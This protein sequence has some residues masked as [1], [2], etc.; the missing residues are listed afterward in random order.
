MLAESPT[1]TINNGANII[2]YN[3]SAV[4]IPANQGARDIES[5]QL[6]HKQQ[7]QPLHKWD[8]RNAIKKLKSQDPYASQNCIL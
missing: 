5:Q 3:K 2:P 1:H 6:Q 4:V 7:K 8:K